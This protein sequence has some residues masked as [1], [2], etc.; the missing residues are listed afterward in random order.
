MMPQ[1][2][3]EMLS[4][5]A[6]L[7]V[8]MSP[9]GLDNAS[10]LQSLWFLIAVSDAANLPLGL[11][12]RLIR[13]LFLAQKYDGQEPRRASKALIH[14]IKWL[15]PN[16][17]RLGPW[18]RQIYTHDACILRWTFSMQDSSAHLGPSIVL[19]LHV[20]SYLVS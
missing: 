4:S 16:K 13:L 11:L 17:S 5:V 3:A 7:L 10:L 20:F 8:A 9:A 14:L 2:A 1:H 18:I 12:S 15:Q 6:Q 19:H